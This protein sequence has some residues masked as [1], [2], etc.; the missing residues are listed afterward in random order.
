MAP[1]PLGTSLVRRSVATAPVRMADVGGWTD[2]WFGSPGQVCN[3]AVGPGVVVEASLVSVPGG[4]EGLPLRIISPALQEDYRSG[5][6]ADRGWRWPVANRQP[7]LEHAAASVLETV[8]LPAGLSVE[9]VISSAVPAGASLGT[10]GAVV[11]ALLGALDGLFDR[12]RP[13]AEVA[14]AAHAVETSRAGRESGVQDQWSAAMG[15]AAL[16]AIGPYPDVRHQPVELSSEVEAELGERLVTVVFGP[17]DSSAV[18][19]SVIDAMVGCGGPVHDQARSA[20]GHLSALAADAAAALRAGD[21]DTWAKVLTA[22]TEGQRSLHRSLVGQAHAAAIEV[23][24]QH[25]ASGWKVNGAGGDGGSLTVV[26]AD[27]VAAAG[28]A[29]AL[30]AVDPS[31][32]VVDL[33]LAP[34]LKRSLAEDGGF[35]FG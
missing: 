33:T 25:G 16:L 18:H 7:L 19:A 20:L 17:H 2:T 1:G 15:G 23:A 32:Q 27:P 12:A 14:V 13:A 4:T 24:R 30:S 10:S 3:L 21:I 28:L 35:L 22:C 6:S 8:E 26:A 11:V 29:A 5:P 9:V 34:G 31:W